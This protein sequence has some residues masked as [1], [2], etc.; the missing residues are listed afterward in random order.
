MAERLSAIVGCT[1][2]RSERVV[3]AVETHLG[4]IGSVVGRICRYRYRTLG[5]EVERRHEVELAQTLFDARHKDREYLF[6]VFELYLGLRRMYV[7]IDIRRVYF[8][9]NEIYRLCIGLQ[10]IV[11]SH[12]YRLIEVRMTHKTPVGK[13]KLSGI[14]HGRLWRADESRYFH[15]IGLR[16]N[17]YELAGIVFCLFAEYGCY[18]L[19]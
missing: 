10:H 7:D 18:P 4:H 1:V 13:E 9:I 17:R 16:T 5:V 8:D 11:V 15:Y 14:A 3:A 12:L 6:F 19:L 2:L